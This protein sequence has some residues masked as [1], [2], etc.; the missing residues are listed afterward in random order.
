LATASTLLTISLLVEE[1]SDTASRVPLA[2]RSEEQV[3]KAVLLAVG[4]LMRDGGRDDVRV[5]WSSLASMSLD[6]AEGY[7]RC[8]VCHCWAF[9]AERDK[10]DRLGGVS[11]GAVVGGRLRCDEHLPPGHP[12]CFVGQG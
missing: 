7:G 3:R 9:D 2:L 6:G 12:L 11:P 4:L 5:E 8:E 1:D 10:G